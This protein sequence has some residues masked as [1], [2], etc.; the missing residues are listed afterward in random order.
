[1]IGLLQI[2]T[3]VIIMVIVL[4][5]LERKNQNESIVGGI[6]IEVHF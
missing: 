4:I 6:C 2:V 1:M 3:N 5:Q